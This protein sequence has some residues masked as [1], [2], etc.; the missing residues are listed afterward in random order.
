MDGRAHLQ[1][2]AADIA[3]DAFEDLQDAFPAMK[4]YDERQRER[5][6]ED[7]VYIVRFAAAILV[8]DPTA[9]WDLT[10]SNVLC[11]PPGAC[12][13]APFDAAIA[14]LGDHMN[15]RHPIAARV[16]TTEARRPSE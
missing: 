13:R 11:S 7:L 4:G 12:P 6:V 3:R 2:D 1:A 9:W 8:A 14:V 15:E 16:L 10:S 5:T